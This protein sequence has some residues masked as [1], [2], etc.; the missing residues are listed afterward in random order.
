[1]HLLH[2]ENGNIIPHG[3]HDKAQ[4]TSGHEKNEHVVLLSYMLNHNVSHAAE[5]K[6]LADKMDQ[7]GYSEVVNEIQEGVACFMEGNHHLSHALEK[8]QKKLEIE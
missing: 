6:E 7:E 1:M 8:L 5:L 3:G 4:D 2:D